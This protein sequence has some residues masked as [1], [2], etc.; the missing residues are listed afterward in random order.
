MNIVSRDDI[1]RAKAERRRQLVALPLEEKVRIME[2][3]QQVGRTMIA[4]RKQ[5]DKNGKPR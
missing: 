5:K 4:A 3:L 1:R 2:Q